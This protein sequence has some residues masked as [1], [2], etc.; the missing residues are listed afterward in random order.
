[1]EITRELLLIQNPWWMGEK[2]KF[3]PVLRDY[4]K[5]PIKWES[6]LARQIDLEKPGSYI[7]SGAR[8][9]GK[10]TFIKTT[11]EML[12][13]KGI[14]AKRILYFSCHNVDT[15]EQ[16]NEAVKTFLNGNEN[17]SHLTYIFIDEIS[18]VKNWEHG[19][20]FLRDAGLLKR[21]FVLTSSYTKRTHTNNK[22]LKKTEFLDMKPLGFADFLMLLNPKLAEKIKRNNFLDYSRK[23]D[24]YLD[25]FFLTGGYLSAINS[26]KEKG[27]VD[28]RVYNE[29][30]LWAMTDIAKDKRDLLLWRQIM[31]NILKHLTR[32][33]GYKTI[34]NKS[35]ARTHLTISEYLHKL[36]SMGI[37]DI[38]YQTDNKSRI[39]P[40]GNKKIYFTDPFI[41]WLYE[42]YLNGAM[43]F[44][45][46]ACDHLSDGRIGSALAENII[47]NHLNRHNKSGKPSV[48]FW[49]DNVHFKEIDFIDLGNV[50][51][52]LVRC[53]RE[54]T[55]KDKALFKTAGFNKGVIISANELFV[56]DKLKIMPLAYF[57]LFYK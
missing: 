28:Q 14:D 9:L 47:W 1:M 40:S 4:H 10:T 7:L 33:I 46:F 43:D 37:I 36:E 8:G 56:K 22:Y 55:E 13:N 17:R 34:A 57:L 29:L 18:M 49:R 31:E 54:I 42:S 20:A 6:D 5:M 39:K 30:I 2:I 52:I 45:H 50:V 16:L 41:L 21:S 11:I 38:C 12:I 27:A 32:P 15:Y 26:F 23:L 51:P 48:A 53:D 19:M 35:K 24:Y 44:W 25:I 3:D